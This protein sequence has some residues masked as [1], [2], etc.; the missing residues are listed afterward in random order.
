M[1]NIQPVVHPELVKYSIELKRWFFN[2][3]ILGLFL[4]SMVDA[5]GVITVS[6]HTWSVPDNLGRFIIRQIFRV[7]VFSGLY[8]LGV[9]GLRSIFVSMSV[10]FRTKLDS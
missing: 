10:A 7:V 5:T 9:L 1:K 8:G 2:L 3:I 4:T 6:V